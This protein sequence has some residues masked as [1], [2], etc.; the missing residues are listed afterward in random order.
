MNELLK[1]IGIP[2]VVLGGMS[3]LMAPSA[4]KAAVHFGIGIGPSYVAPAYAYPYTSP[5]YY[6][7][8]EPYAYPYTYGY[9]HPLFGVTLGGN[10]H[11]HHE[12]HRGAKRHGEHQ[13]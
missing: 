9:N 3:L 2:A 6:P 1:K 13:H 12:S 8:Y 5:Y 11:H 7:D 4:A 10:H